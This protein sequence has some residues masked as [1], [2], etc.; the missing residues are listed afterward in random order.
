MD[1]KKEWRGWER[2]GI[3]WD[4]RVPVVHQ[5]RKEAGL[6][7]RGIVKGGGGWGVRGMMDGG[8]F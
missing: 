5:E 3:G 6:R 7:D 4:R 1:A 2:V 8:W